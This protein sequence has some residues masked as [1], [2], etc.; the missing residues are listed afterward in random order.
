MTRPAERSEANATTSSAGKARSR[1]T[2]SIVLPTAPVAPTTPTLM[3]PPECGPASRD[4]RPVVALGILAADRVLAERERRVEVAHRPLDVGLA[5]DAGDLDGRGRD[6]LDV[7]AG[8][9]EHREGLGRDARVAL[10]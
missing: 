6:H 10:H 4:H 3:A 2:P 7:D 8:V 5:H 9:A 1:I